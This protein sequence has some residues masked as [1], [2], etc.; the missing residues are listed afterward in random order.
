M[1]VKITDHIAA[2]LQSLTTAEDE[3]QR[4]LNALRAE[5]D[6]LD[7]AVKDQLGDWAGPASTAYREAQGVWKT[8]AGNMTANLAWLQKVIGTAHRNYH[9]A[10]TTNLRMWQGHR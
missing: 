9:S 1:E 4:I 6:D 10:R 7:T 3:F 2:D 8:S 5:L